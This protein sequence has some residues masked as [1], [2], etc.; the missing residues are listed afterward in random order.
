M[1][2]EGDIKRVNVKICRKPS[3]NVSQLSESEVYATIK[4]TVKYQLKLID[5]SLKSND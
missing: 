3:S 4:E 1:I 5:I 2:F